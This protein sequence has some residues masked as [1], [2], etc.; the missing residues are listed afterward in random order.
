MSQPSARVRTFEVEEEARRR[1]VGDLREESERCEHT[2]TLDPQRPRRA[3]LENLSEDRPP[4]N[5]G[6]DHAR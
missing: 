4:R 6:E 5:V 3:E 2:T 1:A